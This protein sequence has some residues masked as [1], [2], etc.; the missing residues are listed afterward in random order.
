MA[1]FFSTIFFGKKCLTK[2]PLTPIFHFFFGLIRAYPWPY[3]RDWPYFRGFTVCKEVLVVSL[4]DNPSSKKKSF[5][6]DGKFSP[7]HF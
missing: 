3:F 4:E 6:S 1:V 2:M 7:Q 5:P